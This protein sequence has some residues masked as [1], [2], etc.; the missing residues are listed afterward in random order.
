MDN[1]TL[2]VNDSE[3]VSE[4]VS[5]S[6]TVP[7]NVGKGDCTSCPYKSNTT[8]GICSTYS[9][10]GWCRQTMGEEPSDIQD[11]KAFTRE[12]MKWVD[13][14][15]NKFYPIRILRAYLDYS[16][17]KTNPPDLGN[18]MNS[19]QRTRNSILEKAISILSD[20]TEELGAVIEDP[21]YS[22]LPDLEALDQIK[23]TRESLKKIENKLRTTI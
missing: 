16:E 14:T 7:V 17:V 2:K 6:K 18:F 8:S 11:L 12:G 19:L 4:T 22:S 1:E 3:Q 21:F 20:H 5:Y 10:Y 23:D 15:P 9:I 13:S